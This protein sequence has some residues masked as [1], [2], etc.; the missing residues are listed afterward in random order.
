MPS[1]DRSGSRGRTSQPCEAWQRGTYTSA[2][3]AEKVVD[4]IQRSWTLF[5]CG[6]FSQHTAVYK[7]ATPAV[8][9]GV[10]ERSWESLAEACCIAKRK[11]WVYSK[12][13]FSSKIGI[14]VAE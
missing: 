8:R 13:V 14:V 9:H 3:D 5:Q 1:S 7:M 6:G 11:R 4:V 2:I 10:P 12:G